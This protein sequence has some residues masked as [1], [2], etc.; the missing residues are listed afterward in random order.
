MFFYFDSSTNG[1]EKSNS[2]N[3][4]LKAIQYNNNEL[5]NLSKRQSAT[6]RRIRAGSPLPHSYSPTKTPKRNAD[7]HG[8]PNQ[9]NRQVGTPKSILKPFSIRL[10]RSKNFFCVFYNQ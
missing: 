10:N 1:Y 5:D 9:E 7:L 8:T 2:S 6:K 3:T 4:P